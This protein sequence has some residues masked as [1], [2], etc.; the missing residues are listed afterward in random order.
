MWWLR[1]AAELR[2]AG[3][4][5]LS[6]AVVWPHRTARRFLVAVV[7]GCALVGSAWG[8]SFGGRSLSWAALLA[9]LVAVAMWWA[10]P[11]AHEALPSWGAAWW[12]LLGSAAAVYGCVPETDQMREVAVVVVAGG[13]AEVLIRRRLPTPALLAAMALVEW[14][15]LYGATGQ[16]RAL[17]GGL[18]ALTPLIAV[19]VVGHVA[20]HVASPPVRW[21]PSAGAG[22]WVATALVVART[23][24]IATSLSPAVMAAAV[25]GSVA[26]ALSAALV[27]LARR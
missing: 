14:S 12:V 6:L 24:G 3:I 15:A 18:F 27:A 19:A 25:G 9:L 17:V 16:G 23:G 21:L 7:G 13:V 22:V 11:R 1:H 5:L 8:V 2:A 4:A 26:A 10:A 20:G